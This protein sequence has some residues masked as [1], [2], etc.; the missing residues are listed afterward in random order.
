M[1]LYVKCKRRF[2]EGWLVHEGA[3]TELSFRNEVRLKRSRDHDL[4]RERDKHYKA[5]VS[6]NHTTVLMGKTGFFLNLERNFL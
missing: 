4:L 5:T 3:D 1:L 6:E 2:N